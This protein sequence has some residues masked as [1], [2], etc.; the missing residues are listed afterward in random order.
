MEGSTCKVGACFWDSSFFARKK[1]LIKV[2]F[3]SISCYAVF[4]PVGF[5]SQESGN[6]IIVMGD[7]NLYK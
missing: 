6:V 4:F 2:S 3:G 5:L 7:S 1:E